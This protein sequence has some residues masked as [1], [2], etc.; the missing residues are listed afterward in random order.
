MSVCPKCGFID[1]TNWRQNRW[2][3]NVYFIQRS[4]FR[5]L[6]PNLE[7]KLAKGHPV[8][9]DNFYAYQLGGKGKT[10]VERILIQEYLAFGLKAFHVPR[11]HVDH[12]KDPWQRKLLEVNK[13]DK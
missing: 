12:S 8:A 13:N 3:T 5:E 2:R 10:I 4:Q 1:L 7:D 11:E 9:I 6:K